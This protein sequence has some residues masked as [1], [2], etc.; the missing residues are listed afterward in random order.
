MRTVRLSWGAGEDALL[1]ASYGTVPAA[2]LAALL[3]RSVR[4]LRC[5]A[6]RLGLLRNRWTA[7]EDALLRRHAGLGNT[8]LAALLGFSVPA[9]RGRLRRLGLRRRVFHRWTE[10]DR[11]LVVELLAAGKSRKAVARRLGVSVHA[12]HGLCSRMAAGTGV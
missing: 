6:G 10:A 2:E 8:E 4:A 12:I 5:R 3:G 9:V 7:H 1:Q 11:S